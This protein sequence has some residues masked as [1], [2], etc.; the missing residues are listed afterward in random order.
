MASGLRSRYV[1]LLTSGS[2]L[3]LLAIAFEINTRPVWTACF[4]LIALISFFAWTSNFRRAQ[5][6]ADTPTSKIASAAQGYVELYGSARSNQD[7]IHA[8]DNSFPCVW[9]R[10][11]TYGTQHTGLTWRSSWW[12]SAFLNWDLV[13][14]TVSETLFEINDGSG[15][16]F[17]DPDDAE[18]ITTHRRTWNDGDYRHVEE[19][20]FASDHIYV[21]G[22]FHTVGGTHAQLGLKE[23]MIALLADWKRNTHQLMERFDLNKDGE[24]D[25]QEW[26]LARREALRE[27]QKIHNELHQAP[28]AHVMRKPASGQLY[29]IS[30]LSPQQ[31]KRKYL[32]WSW[33][34]LIIFFA[35]LGGLIAT[36]AL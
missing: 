1:N 16:C 18:I 4:V 15:V 11:A 10:H 28:G 5:A 12:L 29:L 30:N 19:Q 2:H 33:A 23:D 6:I 13:D 35:G 36:G 34:H 3:L 7:L 8:E 27:V 25:L 22:E 20:L 24:I 21:L 32:W 9:Y 26:E 31:I 17:I 14:E